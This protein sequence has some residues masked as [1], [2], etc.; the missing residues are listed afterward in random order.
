MNYCS[1]CLLPDSRPQIV[2]N[3]EGVCS[4][5]INS[6]MKFNEIDWKKRENELVEV[7]DYY[8]DATGRNYDCIIPVSGGKDSTWQVYNIK[9]NYKMNP[10]ALTWKCT[11]RTELGRKNLDNLIQMGVSHIDFT[12]NP[13]VEKKFML[14]TFKK[15]GSPSLS[16]HMAIWSTVL[17]FAVKLGIPLVIFGE[18]SAFE[19]GGKGAVSEMPGMNREWLDKFGVTDGTTAADW[20]G[21]DLSLRD[22]A[23]Y[24]Y[25][26]DQ[27]L[28]NAGVKAIFLGYFLKWDPYEVADFAR[29]VGFQWANRP[30][31][32]TWPY[33]DLDADF[34]VIHHFLK[35]FKFGF[36]RS[37]DNLS[38]DIRNSRITRE[39]AIEYLNNNIEK[40]PYRQIHSLCEYLEISECD[41]WDIVEKHR[42]PDVWIKVDNVWKI[43]KFLEG[44]KFDNFFPDL[45]SI[46]K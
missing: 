46:M 44:L 17:N 45:P 27:E 24:I 19:Y 12:I 18:N 25:P 20:I 2:I 35:W 10:L 30:V 1:N 39:K 42:N 37:F 31:L 7:L 33:A 3:N 34:I 11:A 41:F 15:K 32:G 40:V 9:Y 5:C 26:D 4:A 14:E 21:K 28:E 13:H 38:I 43:K 6:R 22:V 16:E 29:S 23:P 36:T 8:R